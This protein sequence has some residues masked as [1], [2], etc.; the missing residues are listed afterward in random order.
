VGYAG[1]LRILSYVTQPWY[2]VVLLVF[3]A[4]CIEILLASL[5]RE[6]WIGLARCGFALVF[7]GTTVFPAWQALQARQTNVDLLARRI[8][9][10]AKEGDL[11]F[12]SPWNYGIT[13][14]RYYHGE[15]L[16]ATLPPVEDL[17]FHR[18]DIIKR[19]MMSPESLAP[20]LQKM[21]ETLRAGKT[22]WLVGHLV[23]VAPGQKPLELP[24]GY[25]GPDG[26]V[27]GPFYRAW[28]EQAGFFVQTHALAVES[29]PVPLPAAIMHYENPVLSA[30]RGWR[31]DSGANSP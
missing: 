18:C 14:R 22:V 4:V 9:S 23:P 12:V 25:D 8:D 19:Q 30:I 24:P 3:A 7:I 11:I 2:Y 17:R 29:V 21:G 27:T 10:L 26:F 31:Q 6:R 16:C 28:M 1:F 15:T 20:V 13:F 5:P